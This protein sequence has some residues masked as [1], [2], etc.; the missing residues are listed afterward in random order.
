MRFTAGFSVLVLIG[1]TAA[2]GADKIGESCTGIETLQ[3]DAQAPKIV[4]Y[5]LVFSADLAAGSY[6]YD[7]CG[8]DQTYAISSRSSDPIKLTDMD[9]GGQKRLI[10]FD[11]RSAKLADY[12]VINVPPAKVVR[13]AKA[14]CVAAAFHEPAPLAGGSSR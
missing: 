12:Q 11:R 7:K 9:S 4:P 6:C 8:P 14:T 13:N 2:Y 1:S 5:F 10:T 3:I